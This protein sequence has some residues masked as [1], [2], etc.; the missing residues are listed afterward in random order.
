M[1]SWVNLNGL[2]T[3][4]AEARV[5]IFDR[6]FLFGD[7]VYEVMRT[8]DN[9]PLFWEEHLE[10]LWRS[11]SLLQI[12]M[13]TLDPEQ[14]WEETQAVLQRADW[15]ESYL[16]LIITRGLGTLKVDHLGFAQP[17]RVI[18]AQPLSKLPQQLYEQG[19]RLKSFRTTEGGIDPR[20]KSSNKLRAVMAVAEAKAAG[21]DEALR[22]DPQNQVLEGATSTLFMVR[23]AVL[24]TPPLQA[25][26]LEGI[27]RAKIIQLAQS[28]KLPIYERSFD[29]QTLLGAEEVF[30]C[31]SIR[32]LW[33]VCCVDQHQFKAPGP[34][35]QLLSEAYSGHLSVLEIQE[36]IQLKA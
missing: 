21:A 26:I 2:V 10:R 24:W 4:G 18:I 27:T 7:S 25:G 36:N 9:N 16:R 22:L 14:L 29:L 6:G 5:S 12:P 8:V 11:A 34:L 30:I 3:A 23:D 20:I 32:G 17:S 33:P 28:M 19:C 13:H 1:L 31:S 35:T 15:G